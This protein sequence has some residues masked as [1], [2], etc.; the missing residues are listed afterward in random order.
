MGSA[1]MPPPAMSRLGPDWGLA[2]TRACLP[3]RQGIYQIYELEG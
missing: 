2:V 3:L 1:D